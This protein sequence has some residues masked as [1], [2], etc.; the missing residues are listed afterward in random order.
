MV[1]P[2]WGWYAPPY[3]MPWIYYHTTFPW[4]PYRLTEEEEKEMLRRERDMLESRLREI[5]KRLKELES[6]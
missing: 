2:H 6:D 1:Y 3:I 5:N 4:S